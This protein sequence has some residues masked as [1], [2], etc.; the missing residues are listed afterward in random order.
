MGEDHVVIVTGAAGGLG[1]AM[2]LGLLAAGRRVVALDREESAQA[3]DALVATAKGLDEG[4]RIFAVC[5]S[6]RSESDCRRAVAQAVEHF[7]AV[8]ALV[9]NAGLGMETISL[10]AMT[11]GVNF[12]DVPA[13]KWKA[14]IDTNVNGPF[15]MASA[16]A[17][18]LI[19]AGWGKIIN[20]T[21][22]YPTMLKNG[23]SPYGPAKAALESATVIWSKD[24]K[25]TGVTANVLIPGG[26]ADTAMVPHE[27]VGD[28]STLVRPAVM[29]APVTWLT[30]H[31]SDGVT[32]RR[33]VAREWDPDAADDANVRKAG[34]LAGW[35]T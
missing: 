7:G 14:L 10:E 18:H 24:L 13:E 25:D 29:V 2:S 15:L 32:A 19:K 4:A 27:A 12:F 28:R 31:A 16:V 6:V 22:S 35:L 26:A 33:F 34:A 11:K 23:F 5:A 9:N 3:L 30:S 20:V 8:H 17:P 1:R 21:T